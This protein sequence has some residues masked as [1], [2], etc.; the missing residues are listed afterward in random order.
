MARFGDDVAGPGGIDRRALAAAVFAEPGGLRFLEDLIHPL[1]GKEREAWVDEVTAADAAPPA[2]VCEVPLLFEADLADVFDAI[3]VVTA[4]AE[5][6]RA[7]VEARG[8]DFDARSRR[9]LPEDEKVA[10]ADEVYV[11]HGSV[12][13][14]NAWAED[15]LRRWGRGAASAGA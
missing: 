7:R 6:R 8:Q 5:V 10:R 4:D 2:M 13:D 15:V 1:I 11:N 12:E 14:L 3:L 9:Q